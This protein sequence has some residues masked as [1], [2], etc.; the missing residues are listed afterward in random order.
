MDTLTHLRDHKAQLIQK[1]LEFKDF[2]QGTLIA[3][4]RKCGKPYCHCAKPGDPG[5]GPSW[6]LTRTI[7]GKT[8]TKI[9]ALSD[10]EQTKQQ[11]EEY[12][13]FRDVIDD[14]IE[15]NTQI[16]D[17]MLEQKQNGN[18]DLKEAE[19]RGSNRL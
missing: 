19:K 14:F 9:I 1:L 17:S 15:T 6:S 13:R 2:R 7:N 11:I 12:H 3:R 4:Y 8:V 10:V 18:D 16:C 5:H